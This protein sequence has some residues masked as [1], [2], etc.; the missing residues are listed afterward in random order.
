MSIL[1][2]AKFRAALAA[3]PE[4]GA[5][6]LETFEDVNSTLRTEAGN[7][8]AAKQKVL[9]A[10]GL[11]DNENVDQVV[12][13]VKNVLSTLKGAG[14]DPNQILAQVTTLGAQVKELTEKYTA[15]ET[16]GQQERTKRLDQIRINKAVEALT[17]GKASNPSAL[18]KVIAEQ[19]RAKD[20]ESVV[21]MDGDKELPVNDG[22]SAWLKANPWA[23]AN[24]QAAGSGSGAGGSG[25]GTKTVYTKEQVKAMTPAQINGDWDNVQASMTAWEGGAE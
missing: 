7:H 10:L 9:E 4:L 18:A 16:K 17:A 6:L 3:V 2:L 13:N 8:R 1:T 14:N 25:G 21:F 22:V 11:Q 20:D 24:A 15:A 19:I 5:D 12:G 23:V